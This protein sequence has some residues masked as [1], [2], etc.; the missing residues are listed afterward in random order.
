VYVCVLRDVK[1]Y[2]P[3]CVCVC[4]FCTDACGGAGVGW[5]V[6]VKKGFSILSLIGNVSTSSLESAFRELAKNDIEVVMISKGASK[7]NVSLVVYEKDSDKALQAL[8]NTFFGP[9]SDWCVVW[10]TRTVSAERPNC[11]QAWPRGW[12]GVLEAS[13]SVETERQ[14]G[15]T[16]ARRWTRWRRR[17]TTVWWTQRIP[18]RSSVRRNRA[19]MSAACTRTES[20][21]CALVSI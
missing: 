18:S 5:D 15:A 14:R 19:R 8:H 20:D 1:T 4:G 2:P 16:G 6:Q 9:D 17:C 7:V 12:V 10:C 13:A 21:S 11:C 3:V